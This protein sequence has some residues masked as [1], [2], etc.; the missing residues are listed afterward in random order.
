MIPAKLTRGDELRVV[1]PATSLSIIG[2][3]ERK[4]AV[5]RFEALGLRVTFSKHA[6]ECD[7]FNSS[8]VESRVSDIH[9]AFADTNVKA[10]M[11]TLGGFNS[12]QLL[13]HLDWDLIRNNP[14]I[15]CGYSDITA[16]NNAILTK[17]GLVTYSGPHFSTFGMKHGFDY[18]YDHFKKCLFNDDIIMIG[19]SDEW[20]CDSWYM[21]QENRYFHK[22]DG[23]LIINVGEAEGTIIGGH[24]GTLALLQ[25]T[26]FMPDLSNA[27]LFLEED[28]TSGQSTVLMF[29][30]CLQ[31]LIQ[32]PG[33]S[34][35]K[36]I[37]IGRFQKNTN[38]TTEQIVQII[39]T[40]PELRR[41]PVVANANFG[42]TSPIITFP[43]GGK[44]RMKVTSNEVE[45]V[46]ESH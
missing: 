27:I 2:I 15:L 22:H 23:Y 4:I 9:E 41:I 36:G 33:F 11:T 44:A 30:R 18:T 20:S 10:I 16:L 13:S 19:T 29:E 25:G 43:I 38:T 24:L 7:M 26:E 42:H 34:G 3:N 39:K 21:D 40:K 46:I 1:S 8:S 45:L 37:V 14:K 28:D 35:V 32:Q 5:E 6:E 17:T 12:N 31:S